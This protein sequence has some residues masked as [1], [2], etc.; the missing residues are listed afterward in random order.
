[1]FNRLSI[2]FGSRIGGRF[3]AWFVVNKIE[4]G[5]ARGAGDLGQES[6]LADVKRVAAIWTPDAQVSERQGDVPAERFL[7]D[8]AKGQRESRLDV[9][10]IRREATM[11]LVRRQRLSPLMS[12]L[13]FDGEQFAQKKPSVALGVLGQVL[14]D[15][16]LASLFPG[17]LK[18]DADPIE[19]RRLRS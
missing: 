3:I 13:Q 19:V 4:A 14:L 7:V 17:C 15:F 9:L 1:M 16:R 8:V 18:P 10:T 5:L 11:V 2:L 12:P 6:S